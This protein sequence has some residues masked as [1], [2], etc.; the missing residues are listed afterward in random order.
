VLAVGREDQVLEVVREDLGGAEVR[1]RGEGAI[2]LAHEHRRGSKG[3]GDQRGDLAEAEMQEVGR[4]V[5][6][7]ERAEGAVREPAH[8]V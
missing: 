7:D 3:G 6:R 1:A 5:R 4:A 8:L 2:M